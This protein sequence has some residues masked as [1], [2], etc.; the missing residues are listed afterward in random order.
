MDSQNIRGDEIHRQVG[1]L[2]CLLVPA[3]ELTLDVAVDLPENVALDSTVPWELFEKDSSDGISAV[4]CIASM[5]ADGSVSRPDGRIMATIPPGKGAEKIRQFFL[6]KAQELGASQGSSQNRTPRFQFRDINEVS[7]GLFDGEKRVLVYNHGRIVAEHVPESDHRKTRAC[8][9]H[10]LYGLDGEVLT[11]DFPKDHFHHHGIFW[12]WP[13]V[14]IEDGVYDSWEGRGIQFRWV[15]WLA[16]DQNQEGAQF[17]VE[18][19]WFVQDRKVVTERVWIRS[20]RPH[21]DTRVL[22]LD[23][24]WIPIDR[25][26]TLQGRDLKSYGGLTIRFDIPPGQDGVVTVPNGAIRS[27]KGDLLNTPLPWV[28]MSFTFPGQTEPSGAALLVRPDHPDYPPTWLTRCYGPLCIGWP[29]VR[30]RTFPPNQPIAVSY[31]L[32]I[33]R[34]QPDVAMIKTAYG[35]YIATT[36]V[37]WNAAIP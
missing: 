32:W 29:G 11:A 21:G 37:E 3:S 18:N 12:G 22:D 19:G 4:C 16:Q 27:S 10:P 20:Y 5:A 13:Y 34:G 2:P 28:D 1:S 7:L 15:R 6:R 9:I 26:L 24:V 33:H 30:A 35:G 25:P 31:R 8:Y 23:F 17:G 14:K 36:H